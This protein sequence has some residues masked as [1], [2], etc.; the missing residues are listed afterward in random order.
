MIKLLI[1]VVCMGLIFYAVRRQLLRGR[2][3]VVEKPPIRT[4][5]DESKG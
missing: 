5:R 3:H 2:Q 4:V 1:L